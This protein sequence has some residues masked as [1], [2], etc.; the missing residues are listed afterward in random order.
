MLDI[1]PTN[2]LICKYASDEWIGLEVKFSSEIQE[3]IK[4]AAEEKR[5]KEKLEAQKVKESLEELSALLGRL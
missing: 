2:D 4:S 1:H 5:K 3:K